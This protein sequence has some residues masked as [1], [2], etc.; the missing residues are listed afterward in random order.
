[1]AFC[2]MGEDEMVM[3]DEEYED[4]KRASIAISQPKENA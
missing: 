3:E 1:M 4:W 2:P